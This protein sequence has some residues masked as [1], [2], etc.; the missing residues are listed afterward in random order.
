MMADGETII[1]RG[2][3]AEVEYDSATFPTDP[4]NPKKHK[5]TSKKITRV[6]ITGDIS[7]DSGDVPSGLTCEITAFYK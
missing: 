6:L 7:F 3:S 4:T 5:N 1:V 2:G